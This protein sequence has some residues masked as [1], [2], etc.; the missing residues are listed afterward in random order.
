MNWIHVALERVQ[1]RTVVNA[2]MNTGVLRSDYYALKKDFAPAAV[3]WILVLRDSSNMCTFPVWEAGNVTAPASVL[4]VT[5][6][7]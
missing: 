5:V 3:L 4:Q 1:R 2:V 7:T 6:V